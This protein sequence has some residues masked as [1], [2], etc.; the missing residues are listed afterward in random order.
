MRLEDFVTCD[1]TTTIRIWSYVG[2]IAALYIIPIVPACPSTNEHSEFE[3][4]ER[5]ESTCNSIVIKGLAIY[6]SWLYIY[7]PSFVVEGL[8]RGGGLRLSQ[9]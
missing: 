2:P 6:R 9:R 7:I 1:T 8:S 4:Q 3:R 5:K